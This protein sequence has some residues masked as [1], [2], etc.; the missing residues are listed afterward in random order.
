MIKNMIDHSHDADLVI[1]NFL[2]V[3]T[4]NNK[5]KQ[6]PG[7]NESQT[8]TYSDF[9]D[10]YFGQLWGYCVVAWNKLYKRELFKGLEYPVGKIHEDEFIIESLVERCNKIIALKDRLYFYVQRNGSITHNGLKNKGNFNV[11]EAFLERYDLF[12]KFNKLAPKLL[13]KQLQMIPYSIVV[14]LFEDK[15]LYKEKKEQFKLYKLQ[16]NNYVSEF[17]AKEFDKKLFMKR[18]LLNFPLIY[19]LIIKIAILKE[20]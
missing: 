8:W 19:Y 10:Q 5:M 12:I 9:W 13:N 7:L 2:K 3:D 6:E 15:G 16:Y 18:L 17:I 14:G 20:K 1:C 11:A 4:G